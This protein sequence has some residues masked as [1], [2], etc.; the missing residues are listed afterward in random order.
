MEYPELPTFEDHSVLFDRFINL[1]TPPDGS[2]MMLRVGGGSADSTY[3]KTS[4]ANA[5]PEVTSIGDTWMARL[6][7]LTRRH[8]LRVMLD[9]N[10]AV[11]ST[12]MAT[13]LVR[14]ALKALPKGSLAAMAI[15]NEPELYHDVPGLARERIAT[16]FRSTPTNWELGYSPA[17]YARD[18]RAYARA[19]VAVAPEVPLAGA[20]D[21]GRTTAWLR[22]TLMLGRL[23]PRIVTTHRYPLS[24]CA[25]ASSRVF[26]TVPRLLA[27]S[28]T[29][30]M[31]RSVMPW[32]KEAGSRQLGLR[33]TELNSTTCSGRYGV[34][35]TFASALWAPDALFELIQA[36]VPGVNL[37]VRPAR[38]N[39]AF[40]FDGNSVVARPELYGLAM[41]SSMLGRGARL[42]AVQSPQ[43]SA[44]HL[45]V[46]PVRSSSGLKVLLINKGS[47]DVSVRLNAPV[48][49]TTVAK[50]TRL[51]APGTAST[52][53]VTLAGQTIGPD[54]Q[55]RGRR[56]SGSV[57]RSP[58]GAYRVF[59]PGYS[60]ALVSFP[61]PASSRT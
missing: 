3:W 12:A 50:V 41:F 23:S 2:R 16:T 30:G 11:H 53:G 31:A 57:I 58:G 10:L 32:L 17:G 38:P 25:S 15:G 51:T 39:S 22:G 7:S 52:S 1:V 5:P 14:A 59:V 19:L 18:Y 40:I 6:A 44:D 28:A 46:W 8:R 33:V 35:N 42:V 55:W 49:A 47:L 20:D 24:Q 4:T 29:V 34:S 13:G 48:V 36:G 56:L 45:K 27:E 54:M 60:A 43:L 26:P 37:H 61:V 9:L 21:I